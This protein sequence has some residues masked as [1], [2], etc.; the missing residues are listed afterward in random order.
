M[1]GARLIA[2]GRLRLPTLSN[3]PL[4]PSCSH[5]SPRFTARPATWS[6]QVGCLSVYLL[7]KPLCAA[8]VHGSMESVALPSLLSRDTP[9]CSCRPCPATHTLTPLLSPHCPSAVHHRSRPLHF[10]MQTTAPPRWSI[11]CSLAAAT[12]SFWLW[13][14][15]ARSGR[16]MHIYIALRKHCWVAE[17]S[18]RWTAR[19]HS[20]ALLIHYC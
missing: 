2:T 14:A 3:L 6:T 5:R 17:R 15:R 8:C 11:T 9:S 12:A 18:W 10:R 7:T 20:G 13:T 4:L 19:A 1:A 16:H